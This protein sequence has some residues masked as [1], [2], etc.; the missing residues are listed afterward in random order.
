MNALCDLSESTCAEKV[1]DSVRV[2]ACVGKDVADMEDEVVMTVVEGVVV[3]W[4]GGASETSAWKSWG[5]TEGG[6]CDT[7][8]VK[9]T[10]GSGEE[11]REGKWD[12][13]RGG[14]GGGGGGRGRQARG[15]REHATGRASATGCGMTRSGCD[16]RRVGE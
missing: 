12:R 11:E 9:E 8:D 14:G 6:V 1:E 7:I 2:C 3:K 15:G 10:C 4:K 16:G 13:R 5:W